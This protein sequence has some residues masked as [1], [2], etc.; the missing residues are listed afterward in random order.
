MPGISQLLLSKPDVGVKSYIIVPK[1]VLDSVHEE[2]V[3]KG[4]LEP[5]AP[6]IS[7]VEYEKIKS[8][9]VLLDY[10]VKVFEYLN[11]YIEEPVI[12]EINHIQPNTEE[13]LRKLYDK[14]SNVMETIKLLENKTREL[15]RELFISRAL[16]T[17]LNE[18][19]TKYSG[20]LDTSILDYEGDLIVAKTIVG[21]VADVK[22]M[23]DNALK[24]I[25]YV[26]LDENVAIAVLLAER[27][28]YS[29]L[30]GLKI[31]CVDIINEYGVI[32]LNEALEKLRNKIKTI[33]SELL[34][35][36]NK[37]R[38]VLRSNL[39]D[40]GVFKV[41]IDMERSKLSLLE[42][43]ME[44]Q[45]L[46]LIVGWT[47]ESKKDELIEIVNR[48]RG[49]IVF[50]NASNPPVDFKNLRPFK[51][52]EIFTELIGYPSPS[53]RDP[54]PLITYLYLVFTS[55]MLAD[56]GYALGLVIGALFVLPFFIENRDT[57][58][59]LQTIVY[60]AAGV[61]A[62]TGLLAGNFFGSLIG[63]YI[64][65]YIPRL[66]P[67]L[68]PRLQYVEGISRSITQYITISLI[69]G[70]FVIL[71]SHV[72]GLWKALYYRDKIRSA[73]EIV[74][75]GIILLSP[76][77]ISMKL[78]IN[79]EVIGFSRVLPGVIIEYVVYMFIVIYV[80]IRV[81]SDKL[82]GA[83]LWIFDLLGVLTD[84]LSFIR[85]AG[86]AIGGAILA[87]LINSFILGVYVSTSALSPVIGVLAGVFTGM[88]AHLFNLAISSLS[89]FIHS[90]RLVIYE[91]SSKFYEG[92][93]RRMNPVKVT[94]GVFKI[95]QHASLGQ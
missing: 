30:K 48:Y 31:T 52:F 42:K 93:G 20:D 56:T 28:K 19:V 63:T 2:L 41:L 13:E 40:L 90:L 59:R 72:L 70:Y 37:I 55:L 10:S 50:E 51:P 15:E 32:K 16:L 57:L 84:I 68:P 85:I 35:L 71:V 5:L 69:I 1:D 3:K 18:I 65:Q 80:V 88:I 86:I 91:V 8:R 46:A 83:M 23:I 74:L 33:S 79:V 38:E 14:L 44:S 45:Y 47:L 6:S 60:I 43:A 82:I 26:E 25:T 77:L 94:L 7:K 61:S 66:I 87:E 76:S 58:K 36:R 62:I 92:G 75:V 29:E 39:R 34:V 78:P 21:E 49:Y 54:T 73:G 27:S 67:S 9:I 17:V 22:K 12:L 81:L 64:S 11:S 95:G 53:E 89:P 4:L 24:T